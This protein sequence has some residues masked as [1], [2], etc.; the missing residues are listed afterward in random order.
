MT[1][2]VTVQVA[3]ITDEQRFPE[4]AIARAYNRGETP[5]VELIARANDRSLLTYSDGDE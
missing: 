1:P 3:D 5:S 2:F 4:F